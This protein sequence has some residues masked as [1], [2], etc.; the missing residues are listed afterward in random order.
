MP[1]HFWR[2]KVEVKR[3]VRELPTNSSKKI[4]DKQD[5]IIP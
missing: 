4:I 5:K 3:K 1:A 2:K